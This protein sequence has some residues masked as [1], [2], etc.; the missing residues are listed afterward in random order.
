MKRLN[1]K[2]WRLLYDSNV[3]ERQASLLFEAVQ[4]SDYQ[5][6][7]SLKENHRSHVKRIK[8]SS[9]D[10]VLKVPT[11][12]NKRPWIRFVSLFRQGEAFKNVMAMNTLLKSGILTTRPLLAAEYRNKGM[13][14]D[15]WLLYEYLDAKS[16]LD[17]PETFPDVVNTLAR[18]HSNN[19]LH[20]DSQ[21]RNFLSSNSNIYVID[22]NP[23]RPLF[24]P[25]SKAFEWAYLCRSQPKIEAY[26]GV[27]GQGMWYRLAKWYD[28]TERKWK[29]WKRRKFNY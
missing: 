16:C 18:V 13:V 12:K 27:H 7:D 20:G 9:Y 19:L 17:R 10:L 22:A 5:K 2:G 6:I 28:T 24:A 25:F 11:E 1:H 3:D 8:I 23:Q 4:S 26:Y 29:R 14:T 21:I 15:S